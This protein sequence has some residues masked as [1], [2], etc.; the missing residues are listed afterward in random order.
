LQLF[1]SKVSAATVVTI[2]AFAF[3]IIDIRAASTIRWHPFDHHRSIPH[4]NLLALI[5]SNT[6]VAIA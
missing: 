3:A 4:H 2:I 5:N 6:V 1:Y